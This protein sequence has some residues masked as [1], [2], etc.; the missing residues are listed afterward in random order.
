MRERE[1]SHITGQVIQGICLS[2][3]S[4]SPWVSAQFQVWDRVSASAA[5]VF[6]CYTERNPQKQMRS[7]QQDTGDSLGQ[8]GLQR[9]SNCSL[10]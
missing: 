6:L 2:L 1:R 7:C 10:L 9:N 4:G 8:C 3:N 5:Q